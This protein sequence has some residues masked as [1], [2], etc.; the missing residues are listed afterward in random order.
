[1]AK[2]VAVNA[3]P[4]VSMNMDTMRL[5]VIIVFIVVVL[6]YIGSVSA[7][8]WRCLGSALAVPWQFLGG[9]LVVPKKILSL[10]VEPAEKG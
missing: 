2:P 6:V 4:A 8:P 9:A 1:M 7:V 3:V 5:G 10:P